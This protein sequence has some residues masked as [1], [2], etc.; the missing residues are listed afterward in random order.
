M[1]YLILLCLLSFS[2][3]KTI[4]P[5]STTVMT[6]GRV[7]WSQ[8]GEIGYDWCGTR[9]NFNFTGTSLA[10]RFADSKNHYDVTLDGATLPRLKTIWGD[11]TYTIARNLTNGNHEVLIERR[12]EQNWGRGIFKEIIL[13]EE[14][15]LLPAPAKPRKRLLILGDSFTAG[16]GVEHPSQEGN[17]DDYVNTTNTAIAFGSLVGKHYNADYTTLGF[18]GKGLIRNANADSPEKEYPLYY[19]YLYTSDINF[20]SATTTKWN[21][22]SWI[23]EIIAINLGINDFTGEKAEPADTTLWQERYL[24][25]IDTL[26]S[27]FKGVE[28]I[29]MGTGDWPHNLLKKSAAAVVTKAQATGKPVHYFE[30]T[31]AASALHWHPSVS[32]HEEIA[33]G[34]ISLIDEKKL[35]S[36]ATP[37]Q[38]TSIPK[39]NDPQISLSSGQIS[40]IDDVMKKAVV[41]LYDTNGKR[42]LKQRVSFSNGE[43]VVKLKNL[44]SQTA[45][46]EIRTNEQLISKKIVLTRD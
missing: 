29:V 42:L 46:L 20:D 44:A 1:K 8:P 6:M 30:Y 37:L 34:L 3:S 43:A 15:E 11:S 23:P 9:F 31:V 19:D 40:I 16:Y 5:D 28:I 4:Q 27:Q 24:Q 45:L 12:T 7:D 41:S 18:S 2:Y 38:T 33:R 14:G 39:N 13:S 25:F 21:H 10:L 32:E 35:W 36:E 17:Q 26:L 22:Q